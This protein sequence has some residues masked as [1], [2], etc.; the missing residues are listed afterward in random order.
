M[1]INLLRKLSISKRLM[2]GF[3]G[4]VVVSIIAIWQMFELS[5]ITEKLYRHPFTVNTAVLR[6]DANAL[7]LE[8]TIKKAAILPQADQKTQLFNKAK[9][10]QQ[11]ILEDFAV[12]QERFLGDKTKTDKA[13]ELF[14]QWHLSLDKYIQLIQDDSH[15]KA[16]DKIEEELI[17]KRANLLQSMQAIIQ[18]A[19]N[20]ASEFVSMVENNTTAVEA[21][22]KLYNHPFVVTQAMLRVDNGISKIRLVAREI[23]DATDKTKKLQLLEQIK[24]HHQEIE[25]DFALAQERFLG[26]QMILEKIL[27]QYQ[28][29]KTIA[30]HLF[31][32]LIDN[33]HEVALQQS[34]AEADKNFHLFDQMIGEVRT[35]S[36]EKAKAFY[37]NAQMVK[38]N[39]LYSTFALIIISFVISLG[40]AFLT[41]RSIVEPVHKATVFS[42]QLADGNLINYEIM[43]FNDEAG[44]MLKSMNDMTDKLSLVV[45]EVSSSITQLSFASQ[46]IS[47][48]SQQLSTSNSEQAAGLEEV[49]STIEQISSG[50]AQNANNAAHTNEIAE[51]TANMSTTGSQAVE[52]TVKAMRE[53]ASKLSIIEDISYQTNLLALNAAIEAARAGEQGRGFAVVASEVRKL[54]ERSRSAAQDIRKVAASS[55]EVA[56]HAGVLLS[57]M[58]PSIRSTASLIEEIATAS[59]QQKQNIFEIN[60]AM[61]EMGKMT[62]RNAASSEELASISEEMSSQARSLQQLMSFFKVKSLS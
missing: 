45:R 37:T 60:N 52:N 14:K 10:Y 13:L 21:T 43:D 36:R 19:Q 39:I 18:F 56:E 24:Q 46:Q 20:K 47:Q 7:R 53:I 62:E 41:S 31:E 32:K 27:Q 15:L 17:E 1:L 40:L 22:Q 30:G 51:R 6:I 26:D 35:F 28:E 16:I 23:R 2:L 49:A 61:S 25:A 29:W 33:N 58:L 12:V 55:I 8:E 57:E 34:S 5:G 42:R 48:T 38:D 3:S 54:A 9:Q 59:Q 44:Q 11:Q 4:L 50:I